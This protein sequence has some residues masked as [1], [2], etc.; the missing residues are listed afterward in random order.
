MPEI[1]LLAHDALGVALMAPQP[2]LSAP[3]GLSVN[4]MFTIDPSVCVANSQLG[5]ENG[6]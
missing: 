6:R 1:S 3:A 4:S 5:S 2:V